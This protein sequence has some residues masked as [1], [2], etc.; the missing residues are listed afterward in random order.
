VDALPERSRLAE[1]LAALSLV[2]DLTRGHPDEEALRACLIATRLA[3]GMGVEGAELADVY[4]ATLLRF[5]GCTATS[6]EYATYLGGD[7]IA[8]RR[9]ADMTDFGDA[10]ETF[11]FLLSLGT[12]S[13]VR[14][15]ITILPVA[16][17][18]AEE[19]TRA[20]CDVAVRLASRVGLSE[21]VRRS[22]NE[23]FEHWD[24]KG[25]PGKLAGEAIAIP[26]R[27]ASVAFTVAMFE[28]MAAASAAVKRWSGGA[29]D[30][31]ICNA[32][33]AHSEQLLDESR[34]VDAWDAVLAAEPLTPVR[35]DERELDG[36]V[37]VFADLIDLKSPWFLGNST[38][39]GSLAASAAPALGVDPVFA[40]RTGM[41]RD[42][43]RVSVPTGT[44]DKAEAPTR[45][46]WEQVRLHP[47][48][49]ERILLRAPALAPYAGAS[50]AHHERL[51]GS[52]YHRGS[53][54]AALPAEARLL[55]T[56]DAF[57]ALTSA[58]PHRTA[59]EPDRAAAML[60]A[61]GGRGLL[62]REAV[63][64]VIAAAGVAAPARRRTSA[65]APA[66]LTEREIDV[67]RLLARGL[68]EKQAAVA[69][70]VSKTTVHTHVQHIYGKT[71][72]TSRAGLALFAVENGLV[73]PVTNII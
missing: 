73:G 23:M 49:S 15:A 60:Q 50:G 1:V 41:L 8:V 44:W 5:L 6:H 61:D 59:F 43:G 24:G 9:R 57:V 45:S 28:P 2:T 14:R 3:A 34:S 19:G 52:G 53:K 31:A 68:S 55:A 10:R 16:K 40:R 42:L 46:E 20:H 48:H 25:G 39:V 72:L 62:D 69:L 51:D 70:S 32:F 71:G 67:V 33:L 13:R 17:A 63:H 4:Y 37:G 18:A 64:A 36:I 26:A 21:A 54:A 22:L 38:A 47:Y 65:E 56:A 7:D 58:R 11:A 35:I 30:P 29:L 66:G 12:G 27:F